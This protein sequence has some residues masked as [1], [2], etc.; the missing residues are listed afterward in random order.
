MFVSPLGCRSHIVDSEDLYELFSS[1]ES[2]NL[3]DELAFFALL[4]EVTS[5][6]LILDE[7]GTSLAS[8]GDEDM[9]LLDH[10]KGRQKVT[11]K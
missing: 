3:E 6:P 4:D 2:S 9:T 7:G 8:R 5:A 1:K 11:Q 10:G